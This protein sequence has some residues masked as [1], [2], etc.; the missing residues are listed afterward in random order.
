MSGSKMLYFRGRVQP[1]NSEAYTLPQDQFVGVICHKNK[2]SNILDVYLKL[3]L[4]TFISRL[5]IIYWFASYNDLYPSHQLGHVGMLPLVLFFFSFSEG[6]GRRLLPN[7][8][9][10]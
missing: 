2:P 8:G 1:V 5:F 3:L 6:C 4:S 7:T 9:I 10:S